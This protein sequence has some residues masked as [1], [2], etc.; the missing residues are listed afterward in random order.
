MNEL[1]L[2]AA[3]IAIAVPTE[4]DAQLDRECSG[5]PELRKRLDPLLD[6]HARAHHLLDRPNGADRNDET[7]L[8][9]G[10]SL[11]GP[12]RVNC[13][14]L[15]GANMIGQKKYAEAEPLLVQAYEDS[16]SL[17]KKESSS[18]L[19]AD[20]ARYRA[21]TVQRLVQLYDAWAKPAEAAKWR[22]ELERN[23]K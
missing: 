16:I 10:A 22:K 13:R 23:K 15:L 20:F 3:A 18:E 5:R 19:L 17:A 12:D 21:E 4:R 14:A 2:F 1:D 7:A 8:M 11:T 9:P 6:Q